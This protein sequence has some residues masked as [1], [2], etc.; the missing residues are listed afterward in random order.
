MIYRQE[1]IFI[2]FL[3]S[4]KKCLT[5]DKRILIQYKLLNEVTLIKENDYFFP[6]LFIKCINFFIIILVHVDTKGKLFFALMNKKYPW[7]MT[8][9]C[10]L[11]LVVVQTCF[12]KSLETFSYS[13][14]ILGVRSHLY[15]ESGLIY[16]R[17]QDSTILGVRSQLYYESGLSYTRSQDSAILGVRTH[18]Y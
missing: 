4:H 10:S 12:R 3:S 7:S 14:T 5:F 13:L 9:R 8:S 15:S 17:S 2:K 1:N 6:F 11:Q 18:L 16:T